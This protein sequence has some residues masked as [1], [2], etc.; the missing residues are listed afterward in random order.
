MARGRLLKPDALFDSV[1]SIRADWLAAEG[2]SALLLDLDNTL[3]ARGEHAVPDAICRW[4]R[5]LRARGIALALV[6][7]TDKP[8]LHDAGEQLEAP[9]VGGAMKPFGRGYARACLLLGTTPRACAMVGDQTYTD[10]LG[11]HLFGMRAY[12]VRPLGTEDLPHTK[13]LRGIDHLATR[14]MKECATGDGAFCHLGERS[15]LNVS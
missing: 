2:V 12:L 13:L 4:A 5:A 15:V 9:V 10:V 3:V 1:L 11:A 8:R 7:N 6:S 14:G